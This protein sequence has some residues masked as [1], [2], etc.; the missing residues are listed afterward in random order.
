MPWTGLLHLVKSR[1][2]DFIDH[3]IVG[4]PVAA[5]ISRYTLHFEKGEPNSRWKVID[6]E[7][8]ARLQGAE[9]TRIGWGGISNVVI[10][11]NHVC[12]IAAV[13]RKPAVGRGG[14]HHSEII[15]SRLLSALA[16]LFD[17]RRIDFG[18][19]DAA[20]WTEL[21]RH[22]HS[23]GPVPSTDFGTVAPGLIASIST[24]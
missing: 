7:P 8:R 23:H 16:D 22:L 11:I 18:G 1:R 20:G 17:K 12:G 15:K 21:L 6:Q 2:G 9:D 13:C 3:D 10:N 4:D 19:E 24:I 5:A 14:C